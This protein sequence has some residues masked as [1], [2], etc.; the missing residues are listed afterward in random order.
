MNGSRLTYWRSGGRPRVIGIRP[1]WKRRPYARMKATMPRIASET[2]W[3]ARS[4][5]L[6][7]I[8][9]AHQA[10]DLV[11]EAFAAEALGVG[12]KR[13]RVESPADRPIDRRCKRLGSR[14]VHQQTRLI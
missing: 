10:F 14:F 9:G 12:A 8:T 4:S 7:L 2:T 3:N 6:C 11:A 5:R 13:R 1:L